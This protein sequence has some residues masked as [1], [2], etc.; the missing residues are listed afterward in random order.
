M[1]PSTRRSD[2]GLWILLVVLVCA[3]AVPA[4]F[5]MGSWGGGGM[6]G[7]GTGSVWGWG[8][9][10]MA[11]AVVGVIV[12]LV[13]LARGGEPVAPPAYP[14]SGYAPVPAPPAPGTPLEILDA[15][16]A[17]GEITRDEYLRMR[18]DLESRHP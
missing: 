18:Q 15:R 16:Y 2:A 10:L 7:G 13:L 3:L 1:E 8:L 14:M 12:V 6:M 4:F 11:I 17:R 5:V 9:P